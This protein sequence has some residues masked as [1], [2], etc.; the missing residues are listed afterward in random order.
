MLVPEEAQFTS[1][2][3]LW[4][5]C[6]T[7]DEFIVLPSIVADPDPHHFEKLDSDPDPHES[8]KLDPDRH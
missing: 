1:K 3:W 4:M 6:S 2:N 8:G 7:T 5:H